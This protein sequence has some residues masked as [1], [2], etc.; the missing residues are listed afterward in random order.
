M[1]KLSCLALLLILTISC[2]SACNFSQNLT[3]KLED[4]AQAPIKVDEMMGLLSENLIDDAKSLM[5]PG[6][7]SE[8][9]DDSFVQMIAY[10]AGREVLSME[11]EG[12]NVSTSVG[13]SGNTRQEDLFY[14]ATLSDNNI[15]YINAV[16]IADDAGAGFISFQL[17][18]GVV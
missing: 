8:G 9:L 1:K 6:T 3:D 10:L 14:K 2:L 17:V 11:L 13:T 15:I 7:S 4:S 18:L 12:I 16:Y 5:H